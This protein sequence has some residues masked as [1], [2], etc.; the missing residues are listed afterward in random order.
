[1]CIELLHWAPV[2]IVNVNSIFDGK[3]LSSRLQR[4]RTRLKPEL[5]INPSYTP[6]Q[7]RKV[8]QPVFSSSP[9]PPPPSSPLPPTRQFPVSIPPLL[10]ETTL[11]SLPLPPHRAAQAIGTSPLHH[12]P[13]LISPPGDL[14]S[15]LLRNNS[16][17]RQRGLVR[18]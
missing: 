11:R 1:M 4:N 2:Y 14:K 16:S 15:Q 17:R 6:P 12:L 7:S 13:L 5:T 3:C 8:L 10:A 9:R 18:D